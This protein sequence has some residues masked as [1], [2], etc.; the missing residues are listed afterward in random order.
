MAV[1]VPPTYYGDT[2][3]ATLQLVNGAYALVVGGRDVPSR[4][5]LFS[6]IRGL[7]ARRMN[8]LLLPKEKGEDDATLVTRQ[9]ESRRRGDAGT[10]AVFERVRLRRTRCAVSY[11]GIAEGNPGDH[12]FMCSHV[13][14]LVFLCRQQMGGAL[15]LLKLYLRPSACHVRTTRGEA[16]E[17]QDNFQKEYI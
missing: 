3:L 6:S 10:S 4:E 13:F 15:Y 2:T 17:A 12:V 1:R 14:F 8:N 5:Q 11:A 16:E 7:A 9:R